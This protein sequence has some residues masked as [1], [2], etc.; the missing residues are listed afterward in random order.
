MSRLPS[1]STAGSTPSISTPA[2]RVPKATKEEV[3]SRAL[4]QHAPEQFLKF[5]AAVVKRGRQGIFPAISKEYLALVDKK[6]N[7]V[8]AGVTL[9]R[10]PDLQR[11]R[12]AAAGAA[13]AG[14]AALL[15]TQLVWPGVAGPTRN[16]TAFV[17][18]AVGEYMTEHWRPGALVALNTAGSTPYRAP[19]FRY[20][21]MLGLNDSHIAKRTDVPMRLIGQRLP[22]HAKGDGGYVLDQAPDYIILG[23]ASGVPVAHPWFLSDLEIG[24]D[25]RFRA[26]YR[27][28]R[29]RL[30]VTDRPGF[31]EHPETA[32]GAILF[33]WYE[34]LR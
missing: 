31:G 5:L 13:F 26:Q 9:A 23:P 20:I 10:E 34:R 33:T 1:P 7:R 32:A 3:L 6:F 8:H 28:R 27:E 2:T 29:A 24:E 18:A 30:D 16:A 14:G 25:P 12:P 4:K 15:A 11:L 22:G 19:G 17:G 21:D